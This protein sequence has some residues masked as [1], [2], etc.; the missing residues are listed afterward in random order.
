MV[1]AVTVDGT[2]DKRDDVDKGWRAELA[3]PLQAVKGEDDKMAV[4]IPP[5]TGDTWKLDIV[6]VEK[7]KDGAVTASAWAAIDVSDFH[8]LDR[9]VTVTFGDATGKTDAP[10]ADTKTA[11]ATAAKPA[12]AKGGADAKPAPKAAPKHK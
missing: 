10:P 9:L 11:P 7:P 2:L 8:A 6:R 3:I 4:R 5:R 1:T 12:E